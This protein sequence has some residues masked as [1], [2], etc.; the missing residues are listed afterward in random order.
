MIDKITKI[1]LKM[2]ENKLQAFYD[3]IRPITSRKNMFVELFS[4][5][6][7]TKKKGPVWHLWHLFIAASPSLLITTVCWNVKPNLE[8]EHEARLEKIRA[9]KKQ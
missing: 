9:S 2:A 8:P 1:R 5:T 3:A 7:K 4:K 6:T